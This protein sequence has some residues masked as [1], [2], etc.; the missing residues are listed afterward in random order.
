VFSLT[1]GIRVYKDE[2]E[3]TEIWEALNNALEQ[4]A[5]SSIPES[6]VRLKNNDIPKLLDFELHYEESINS[7]RQATQ[8]YK[9]AGDIE[10]ALEYSKLSCKIY[11]KFIHNRMMGMTTY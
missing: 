4:S 2:V 3:W 11:E 8:F 9:D 7:I 1:G 6:L 10:R 5:L